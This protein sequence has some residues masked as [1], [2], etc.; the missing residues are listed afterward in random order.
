MDGH[1]PE[2][3]LLIYGKCKAHGGSMDR[4]C[5]A[6]AS[7]YSWQDDWEKT[8]FKISFYEHLK[9]QAAFKGFSFRIL[10]RIGGRN[11]LSKTKSPN[12]V[13]KIKLFVVF[14]R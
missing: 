14:K 6:L 13:L 12:F 8:S 7:T 9:Q 10:K 3:A 2:R 4:Q 5:Q 11:W 1:T